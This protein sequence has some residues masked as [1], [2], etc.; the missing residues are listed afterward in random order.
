MTRGCSRPPFDFEYA[1]PSQCADDLRSG[2]VD[3]GIIPSIEY[4]RIDDL[5]I[6]PGVSIASKSR[7][8]SV[9]LLSR[10]PIEKVQ[11][12]AM[13][14]ASRTS[15]ALVTILL[16]KFYGVDFEADAAPPSGEEVIPHGRDAA[17]VIGDPALKL[18]AKAAAFTYDLAAEWRKF[19]GLPFVFA[20]WA[21]RPGAGLGQYS[22]EFA[23]S[24]DFGL[25]HAGDIAVE[26]APRLG[27][28]SE[29]LR[30]YLTENID[31]TLDEDN[32]RGLRLFY[33]LAWELALAPQ[34]RDVEFAASG[35][36][37]AKG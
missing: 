23:A 14:A 8:K 6:I 21:G 5:E 15:A 20:V 24:R 27:L 29:D 2:A 11:T 18:R 25:A 1:L 22:S 33:Q 30:I 10:V 17:L 16:R 19:T 36:M 3:A 31:Y 13:D 37:Q 7:V 4:Q 35:A 32:L 28:D 9:V 12:V 34:E 26:Y